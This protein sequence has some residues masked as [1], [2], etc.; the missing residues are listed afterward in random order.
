VSSCEFL[1]RL[2]LPA[3]T[4][5]EMVR[6]LADRVLRH[7]EVDEQAS[8][9]LAG[10]IHAASARARAAGSRDVRFRVR[11]G[12]LEIVVA[13]AAGREWRTTRPLP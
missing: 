12:A 11:G 2:Q 13:D 7:F 5:D 6:E 8:A 3:E 10:L 4:G 9:E 1:F